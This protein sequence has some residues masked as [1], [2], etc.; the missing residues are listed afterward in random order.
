MGDADGVGDG[1]VD[2]DGV[3]DADFDGVGDGD[4]D[5]VGD[6]G[7]DASDCP[8]LPGGGADRRRP[9]PDRPSAD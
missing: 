7:F 4:L 8:A 2:G 5:G 1:D 3:G 9:A 6:G